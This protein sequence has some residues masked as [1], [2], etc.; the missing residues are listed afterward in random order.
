MTDVLFKC[1]RCRRDKPADEIHNDGRCESCVTQRNY[2]KDGRHYE[3][4]RREA[5]R[6]ICKTTGTRCFRCGK[7]KTASLTVKYRMDHRKWF[8]Q[9]RASEVALYDLARI[10]EN[11]E[12]LCPDCNK[13]RM[14]EELERL[15]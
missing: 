1:R 13:H 10:R 6:A 7:G 15:A 2:D 3:A 14:R 9:A 11:Y 4:I 12:V 8:R 5:M